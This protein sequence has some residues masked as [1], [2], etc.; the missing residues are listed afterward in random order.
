MGYFSKM[1]LS[2]ERVFSFSLDHWS[3]S[4]NNDR[5]REKNQWKKFDY[6]E[7]FDYLKKMT[8]FRKMTAGKIG[9]FM[10]NGF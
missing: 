1:G 10:S 2:L 6:L 3:F 4:E 5:S 7:K 9:S 8:V